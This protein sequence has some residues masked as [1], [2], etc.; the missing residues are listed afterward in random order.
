MT[1]R[2]AGREWYKKNAAVATS[3]VAPR[4]ADDATP[5]HFVTP[6]PEGLLT[7]HIRPGEVFRMENASERALSNN[8]SF[9]YISACRPHI[10]HK[11]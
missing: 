3:A 2:E 4:A 6:E 9:N 1:R 11:I 7:T 8:I 10:V 5:V